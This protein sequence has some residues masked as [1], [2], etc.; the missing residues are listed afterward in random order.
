MVI[1][2]SQGTSRAC[3]SRGLCRWGPSKSCWRSAGASG[4]GVVF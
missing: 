4:V 3:P 2:D 1:G